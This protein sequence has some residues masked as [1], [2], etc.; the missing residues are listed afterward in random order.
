M[1]DCLYIFLDEGGNVDFSPTGTRL[2]TLTSITMNRPFSIRDAWDDAKHDYLEFGLDTEFFHCVK[3]NRYIRDRVFNIIRDHLDQLR[4]D[5]LIIDKAKTDPTL[6][7]DSRFYPEMLGH[8]LIS[9]CKREDL[10]RYREVIVVTDRIPYRRKRKTVEKGI[11][12]RLKV[13]LPAGEKFRVLHHS[14]RSHYGLQVADYCNWAIY[15]KWQ[16]GE[17]AYYDRISIG[18]RSEVDIS[19]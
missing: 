10:S 12:H 7:D 19:G 11:K 4:I 17:T 3:D 8:L 15:R 5:S 9:V 2:F 14:S 13:M 1:A 6:R 16:T 18:I